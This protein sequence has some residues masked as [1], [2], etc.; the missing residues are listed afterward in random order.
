MCRSVADCAMIFDILRGIDNLDPTSR[1][2][3]LLD[4]FDIDLSQM[5]VGYL[6][7]MDSQAPE[8]LPPLVSCRSVSASESVSKLS[9]F[10]RIFSESAC[11]ERSRAC[12]PYTLASCCEAIFLAVMSI[13]SHIALNTNAI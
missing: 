7:G 10:C 3:S 4:P 5:T 9:P 12:P 6:P 13:K 1:D 11:K 2:A 8:V